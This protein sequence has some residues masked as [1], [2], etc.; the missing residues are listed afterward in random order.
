MSNIKNAFLDCDTEGEQ[1]WALFH[2][3][4]GTDLSIN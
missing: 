4:C 1:P 3:L 2:I